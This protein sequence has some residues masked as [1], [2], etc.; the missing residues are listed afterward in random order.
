MCVCVCACVRACVRACMRACVHVCMYVPLNILTSIST[1]Y[2]SG[3][4]YTEVLYC[5]GDDIVDRS[6]NSLSEL[7]VSVQRWSS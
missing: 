1:T 5:S 6:N 7:V 2:I 3:G 4:L